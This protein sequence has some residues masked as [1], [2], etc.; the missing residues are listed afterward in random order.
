MK[1]KRIPFT[2]E[3]LEKIKSEY[4]S[5]KNSGPDA[6]ETLRKAR[7]LGDLSE[8]GLYKAARARLS[9]IDSNLSRLEMLIKLA[10][11]QEKSSE[12]AGI[13]NKVKVKAGEEIIEYQIVGDFEADPTIKK[14]SSHSPIGKALFDKRVGEK[15]IVD[16]PTKQLTYEIVEIS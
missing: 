6:D 11:V 7:E 3:G 9:S 1:I 5:I 14:I 4:Q 2:M 8:N 10:D 13:G 16:L 12:K 15:V